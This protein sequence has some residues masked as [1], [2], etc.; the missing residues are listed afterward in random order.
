MGKHS[1]QDDIDTAKVVIRDNTRVEFQSAIVMPNQRTQIEIV[2]EAGMENPVLFM[3]QEPSHADVVIEQIVVG[4]FVVIVE[5]GHVTDF[6]FGQPMGETVTPQEP[7][8]I[9]LRH[10]YLTTVK[11]GASLVV[12]EKAGTYKIVD[13][14]KINQG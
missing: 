3:S 6:K 9:V 5:P 4:H 2:P 7:L 10:S 8:K 11:V 1:Q 12:S 13:S 14:E